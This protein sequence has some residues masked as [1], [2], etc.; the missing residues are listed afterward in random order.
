LRASMRMKTRHNGI[1]RFKKILPLLL[2]AIAVLSEVCELTDGKTVVVNA[3]AC[4]ECC[5]FVKGSIDHGVC[6]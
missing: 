6:G 3:H 5:I 1:V 2:I 4:I